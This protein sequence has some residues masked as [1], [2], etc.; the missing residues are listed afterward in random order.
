MPRIL[1]DFRLLAGE[2]RTVW[3]VDVDYSYHYKLGDPFA[4]WDFT[5]RNGGPIS[6]FTESGGTGVDAQWLVNDAPGVLQLAGGG[7]PNPPGLPAIGVAAGVGMIVVNDGRVS[8][9]GPQNAMGLGA[10]TLLLNVDRFVYARTK[11]VICSILRVG[12]KKVQIT[13]RKSV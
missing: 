7:A 13:D 1:G 5:F 11:L 9:S 6:L 2:R 10:S 3:A 4:G 8:V 12:N